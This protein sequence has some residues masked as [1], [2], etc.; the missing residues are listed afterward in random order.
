MKL[1][2]LNVGQKFKL[3]NGSGKTW[4]KIS[5]NGDIAE[6][7]YCRCVDASYCDRTR[8]MIGVGVTSRPINK[9]A[10]VEVIC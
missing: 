8:L 1:R 3:T 7:N 10:E 9:N 6:Y 2:D 4:E 5:D